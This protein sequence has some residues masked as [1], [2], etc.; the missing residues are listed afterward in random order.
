[1][2]KNERYT[3]IPFPKTPYIPGKGVRFSVEPLFAPY[4]VGELSSDGAAHNVVFLYGVD[5]FNSGYY[6]EAHEAWE[7]VWHKEGN[8]SVKR[9]IQGLI[10]ITAGFVKAHQENQSGVQQLWGAA[11]EKISLEILDRLGISC[12]TLLQEVQIVLYYKTPVESIEQF[13][14]RLKVKA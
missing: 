7:A 11:V 3:E 14:H 6:W 12:R 2:K 5:L 8:L 4:D 1:M 9:T 13:H 10:Q